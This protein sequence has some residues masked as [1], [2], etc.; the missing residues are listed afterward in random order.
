MSR[1]VRKLKT[2]IERSV[3]K[4]AA[5]QAFRD[6]FKGV[7]ATDGDIVV[8][9]NSFIYRKPLIKTSKNRQYLCLKVENGRVDLKN[10]FV[11]GFGDF[12]SDFK[13]F[14]AKSGNLPQ[15]ESLDEA[16]K[17]ELKKLG[18]LVFV[19]IGELQDVPHEVDINHKIVKK[20]KFDPSTKSGAS[21]QDIGSGQKAVIVN[22]L[23]DPQGAWDAINSELRKA[24]GN[25][26]V[27]LQTAF[28]SAFEKLQAQ[29]R[30]RLVLPKQSTQRTGNSFLARLQQSVSEQFQLYQDAIKKYN[31]RSNDRDRYLREAMR[32]AY[33]FA[34]DAIKVLVL[35]VSICDLKGVLLWCTVKE[36]FDVAEAFRNLPWT[37]SHKKPSLEHY[38]EIIAGARNRAFHNL[39]AFDRTIEAD[40]E[41]I[42]IKA[43]RLTLVPP[44]GRRKSAVPLDY[45]DREMVEILSELTRAPEVAVPIDFWEKNAVVIETF[46]KLLRCT[47][48]ALWL[49]SEC[50]RTG[51]D[52]HN[53]VRSGIR[54]P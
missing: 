4:L 48:D 13:L 44:Y 1:G 49:L 24:I 12:D 23:T 45:E 43:R 26:L 3:K 6:W 35:V 41:G 38:R 19:L 33:N 32:I 39:L 10:T 30:L 2:I 28:A 5:T 36:H 9:N 31:K 42:D 22:Q 51:Y 34:E 18:Q 17:R 8:I 37:K 14:S 29:A 11:G 21:L 7:K 40:L 53:R 15:L 54:R 27:G 46:A 50:A 52:N 20:L 47:E 16:L 25:D